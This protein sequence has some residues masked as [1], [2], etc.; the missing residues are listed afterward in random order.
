MLVF[1]RFKLVTIS[2]NWY[3]AGGVEKKRKGTGTSFL[4]DPD[5]FLTKKNIYISRVVCLCC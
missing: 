3:Y 1:V 4:A 5:R 2:N